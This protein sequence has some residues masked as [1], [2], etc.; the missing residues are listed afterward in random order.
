VAR[1]LTTLGEQPRIE[2]GGVSWT[3]DAR[4]VMRANL[5]LRTAS[6]VLVRVAHFDAK[7]FHEL[8]RH[9]K[10]IDW[11]RFIAAD[12]DVEFRVTARKSKLY[13][14]DAI[15]E[16]LRAASSARRPTDRAPGGDGAQLFVVRAVRDAFDVSADTSGALLHMRGYREAVGKA[17]LRE[18]LAAALLLA[19]EWT[20]ASPLVDPLCGSGT[21]PIEAALIARRMAPGANRDFAFTRWPD[22]NARDWES[23]LK[24]ARASVLGRSPVPLAG[25]DRDAG[26]IEAARANA[27]RAGVADDIDLV[28]RSL[29]ALTP[30]ETTGLVAT[31]PPY[32]KR[33]SQGSD[34]RNLYAQLGKTVKARCKGWRIALYSPE[35]RLTGQLGLASTELFRTSNGGI[36][37]AAVAAEIA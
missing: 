29:S 24:S 23:E 3:G 10:K 2:D 31:N 36:R 26:A 17:P 19:A 5:W 35:P 27:M 14:T 11:A 37:V 32:G 28:T 25:S 21:I 16:R 1:E 6:R 13:H 30:P 33:V 15:A 8:E 12:T 20:G 9:A 4:S 7:T 22:F 18:T 34:I